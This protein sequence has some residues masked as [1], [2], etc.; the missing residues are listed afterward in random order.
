MENYHN[1]DSFSSPNEFLDLSEGSK[2]NDCGLKFSTEALEHPMM[3]KERKY[4]VTEK[5]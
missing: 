1:M 3:T 4:K 2:S 5:K